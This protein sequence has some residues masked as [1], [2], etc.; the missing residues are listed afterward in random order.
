[1]CVCVRERERERERCDGSLEWAERVGRLL[2]SVFFLGLGVF[3]SVSF[4][5][6]FFVSGLLSVLSRILKFVCVCVCVC[7]S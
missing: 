7:V 5:G 6:V 3:C 2:V 4:L 1:M